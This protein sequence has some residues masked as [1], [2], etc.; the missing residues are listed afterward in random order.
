MYE[1]MRKMSPDTLYPASVDMIKTDTKIKDLNKTM[2]SMRYS[3]DCA[4]RGISNHDFHSELI[5]TPA[6]TAPRS[7]KFHMVENI[8]IHCRVPVKGSSGPLKI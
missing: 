1:E 3:L 5:A 7:F 6:Y 2:R 4:L 8:P